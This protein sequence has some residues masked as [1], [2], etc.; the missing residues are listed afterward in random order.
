MR[1]V[2][3]DT[4][5]ALATGAGRAAIAIIRVSGPGAAMVAKALAGRSSAPREA[6]YAR[7]RDPG[8]GETLD[9]ALVLFF[10]AAR[11]EI[12]EDGVEFHI[13]G[14][15][16]VIAAVLG[17]LS[18]QPGLR[19]AEPG[20]F[21]RR[22]F[23]NGK[24]D[25]AQIEGLADL[26]D[27]ETEWQRRQAQRQMSGALRDATA[28][29]RAALI[30]AASHVETAIDFAEDV[31]L[32][33]TLPA[34]VRA[35]IDPIRNALG[36]ELAQGRAAE[37]VR[38]GVQVVIAGPPNAGK[39][40]LLNS[41]VRR[42]AAIVSAFA[43]TTRDPVEVHLDLGGCPVTLVDTAGLRDATEPVEQIG[44][45]RARDRADA[46]DLVLWLAEDELPPPL[47]APVWRIAPK[48]DLRGIVERDGTDLGPQEPMPL[49]AKSGYNIDRLVARLGTFARALAP[50]GA[51]GL[52]TRERHRAAFT[53]ALEALDRAAGMPPLEL[54]AEEL[55]AARCALERLVGAIDAEDILGTIFSRFCI[56]K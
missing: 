41:L 36:E 38:E 51:E 17:V 33:A 43:G 9:H 44:I 54:M 10:A 13:H 34:V 24:M 11:S 22:A 52:L 16:A 12:G 6:T 37:R 20:E 3:E 15:P 18:R 56:G 25:L 53:T 42:E 47:D 48:C 32:G 14:S 28:P 23:R 1:D 5:F 4:I 45:R 50:S 46:A 8:T 49:S 30:E 31:D 55:R 29:W 27:A 2:H 26:I 35:C 40:T 19:P 7:L 21:A 39:S